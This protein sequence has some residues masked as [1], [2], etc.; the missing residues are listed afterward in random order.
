MRFLVSYQLGMKKPPGGGV[1]FTHRHQFTLG[2]AKELTLGKS[3]KFQ[4]K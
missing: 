3:L 4:S 2:D 1:S